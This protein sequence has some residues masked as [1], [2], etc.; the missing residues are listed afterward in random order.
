MRLGSLNAFLHPVQVENREVVISERFQ[1]NGKPV[2][3]VIRPLTEEENENLIKK[4]TKKDKKGNEKFDQMA[5]S[6]GMVSVAVVFP[7]LESAELQKSLGVLGSDK[8]LS[9]LL[10]VG[11]FAALL[12]EVHELSGLDKDINDEVEEAK[13]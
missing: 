3:F 7:D 8:V 10:Y 11:E 12:Q 1:E 9:K 5:Y 6:R 4:Y 2:P 13:N